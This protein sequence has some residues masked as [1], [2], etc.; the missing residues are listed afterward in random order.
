[1]MLKATI[2]NL[3]EVF[4]LKQKTLDYIYPGFSWSKDY[5]TKET[6]KNDIDKGELYL[7]YKQDSLIGAVCLNEEYDEHYNYVIWYSQK[8]ALIIHRLFIDPEFRGKHLGE[9]ILKW[10]IKYAI[11]NKYKSIRL[12][13]FSENRSAQ[14]LY[15]RLGFTHRG[16]I[17]LTGKCGLFWC[18]ELILFQ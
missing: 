11:N 3:N 1:M 16:T 7:F 15:E 10:V 14:R 9:E 13:T 12:D 8:P 18:Y 6:F 2:K 5:P 17:P 4:A